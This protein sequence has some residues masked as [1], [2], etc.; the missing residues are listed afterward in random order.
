MGGSPLQRGPWRMTGLEHP[1]REKKEGLGQF[2]MGHKA[3]GDRIGIHNSPGPVAGQGVQ[4]GR[5]HRVPWVPH[6]AQ[7]C[8]TCWAF[9]S[10]S[11]EDG[12]SIFPDRS[13]VESLLFSPPTVRPQPY[14]PH[15]PMQHLPTYRRALAAALPEPPTTWPPPTRTFFH[16]L[17]WSQNHPRPSLCPPEPSRASPGLA[18]QTPPR[19]GPQRSEASRA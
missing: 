3:F 6:T 9:F 8:T 10:G 13:T 11:C 1:S 12:V 18:V 17:T 19:W 4:P 15:P 14:L 7:V 16:G 5:H 2:S